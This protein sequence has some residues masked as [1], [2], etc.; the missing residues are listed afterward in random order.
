MASQQTV[1][2]LYPS[3]AGAVE[4]V[5]VERGPLRASGFRYD[6]GVE[7]LRLRN[8]LGELV[9]LPF[10]GQQIWS[11]RFAG[12]ELTM[13]SMFDEPRATQG[14]LENYGGFLLHCGATAMGVPGPGDTHPLHGELPNAPYQK[15]W[16]ELGQD[17]TGEYLGLGGHYQ[18]TV[19]FT[20]NY[21][22]EPLVKLYAGSSV[23]SVSMRIRNLRRVPMELMYLAHANF[24]PVDGS[25]LIYSARC[26]PEHVRVR[27]SIPAHVRT[28]PG[29]REYLEELGQH[30]ERHEQLSA[31]Q[32]FDPEVVFYIDYLTDEAGW[33][34]TLQMLPD[35]SADYLRHRPDQLPKGV[36]WICRTPDQDALGMVLPATAEP[37]GYTAEEAKGH[38]VVLPAGGSFGI[39]LEMG[40]LPPAPA[41]QVAET[42]AR[43]V[44]A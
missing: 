13:K 12:R 8:E 20:T 37:E 42:I 30:P 26:T 43:I 9:L 19:A 10:Q 18:H 6:S 15:A 25:R 22:A 40:A 2:P 31:E 29:F 36:R 34:H 27:R 39:E 41:R 21:L 14:Y 11:A 44:A 38:L 32:L 7:G 3:S 33:A 24:R 4:R 17:E 1:I 28:G 35:G 5:L 23:F 16:L